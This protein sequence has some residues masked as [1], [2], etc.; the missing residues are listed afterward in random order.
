LAA[1]DRANNISQ[2]STRTTV[3]YTR[4]STISTDSASRAR[5]PVAKQPD[6]R[7]LHRSRPV[8]QFSAATSVRLPR[9]AWATV[10]SPTVPCPPPHPWPRSAVGRCRPAARLGQSTIDSLAGACLQSHPRPA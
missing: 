3:R 1:S 2:P 9:S 6:D 4:R 10:A 8:R 7:I 5:S